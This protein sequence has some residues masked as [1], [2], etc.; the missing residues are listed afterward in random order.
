MCNRT[1]NY[2]CYSMTDDGRVS[3]LPR[4]YPHL[5]HKS[6]VSSVTLID[7]L[8]DLK[9]SDCSVVIQNARLFHCKVKQEV[10]QGDS[11]NISITSRS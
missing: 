1:T 2:S 8:K 10:A 5:S 7:G 3:D 4:V 6:P 11:A 9:C